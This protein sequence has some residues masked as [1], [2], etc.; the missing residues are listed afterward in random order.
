MTRTRYKVLDN[1]YPYLLTATVIEWL[2]LFS[3]PVVVQIVMNAMQFMQDQKR[4][5]IYGYVIMHNHL[6]MIASAEKL[7]KEFGEF[8]SFTARQMID[9]YQAENK[10]T[11]LKKLAFFKA[12]HR[13]DRPYQFWQE[14]NKPK[15]ID[16][17]EVMIQKLEYVHY[18]PVRSGFVAL[19]E[20]WRYSSARNYLGQE[21]LIPVCMDWS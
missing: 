11:V 8:K 10:T 12:M 16:R 13:T 15:Q 7:S 5:R 20:H 19:P 2:P 18:N 1:T 21:G 9:Y 6:H 14:G 3:N 4:M 17:D